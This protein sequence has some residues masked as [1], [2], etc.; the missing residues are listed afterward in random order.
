MKTFISKIALLFA[1][2]AVSFAATVPSTTE[3]G[4]VTVRQGRNVV[5]LRSGSS[6]QFMVRGGEIGSI[7][8]R[9]PTGEVIAFDDENCPTCGSQQPKPCNG[10]MRCSYNEKYKATICF[11]LPKLDLSNGSND[12]IRANADFYLKIDTIKGES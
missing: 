12:G 9:K 5:R 2:V 6:L 11:C 7:E 3:S 8:V 4:S 10:E 1:V